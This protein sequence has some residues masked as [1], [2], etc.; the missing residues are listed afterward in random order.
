MT[1]TVVVGAAAAQCYCMLS[2]GLIPTALW[3]LRCNAMHNSCYFFVI[4][5]ASIR[6]RSGRAEQDSGY[7]KFLQTFIVQGLMSDKLLGRALI[8]LRQGPCNRYR[9]RAGGQD[10]PGA[11]QHS[12]ARAPI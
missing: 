3:L 10:L 12:L 8:W 1:P 7:E 9:R 6:W 4:F 5:N 2:R 11:R